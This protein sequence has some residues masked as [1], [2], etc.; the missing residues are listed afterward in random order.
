[1]MLALIS[2]EVAAEGE[3]NSVDGTP[4]NQHTKVQPNIR[5]QVEQD[6]SRPFDDPMQRPCVAPFVEARLDLDAVKARADVCDDL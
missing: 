1:M 5:M 2:H 4:G 6:L 3:E